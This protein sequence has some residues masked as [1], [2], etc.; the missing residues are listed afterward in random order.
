MRAT[1][2]AGG[3]LLIG[4]DRRKARSR[5]E[6]AY[7]DAAGVTAEFNRNALVHLAR[8]LGGDI[9]AED[10]DHRAFYDEALGRIEMHLVARREQ[11]LELGGRSYAFS[12]GE[13]IHTENS[14]KY[15]PEEFE[16]LA[17][18]AGFDRLGH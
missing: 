6:P 1:L 3:R 9:D 13:T 12:A 7:A 15:A 8:E 16:A 18:A 4:V 5:V 17:D 14:Y 10:F 2:G 11:V